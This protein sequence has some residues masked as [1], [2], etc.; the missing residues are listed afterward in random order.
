MKNKKEM[1]NKALFK[2][3]F[4]LISLLS[5]IGII[6]YVLIIF[7]FDFEALSFDSNYNLI[8]PIFFIAMLA[9]G[10]Y[11]IDYFKTTFL[12]NLSFGLTRKENMD[13]YFKTILLVLLMLLVF[14][15]VY[16][17]TIFVYLLCKG[18]FFIDC[19][20]LISKLIEIEMLFDVVS[21]YIFCNATIALISN[22]LSKILKGKEIIIIISY[23]L[24]I[25][26]LFIL[27]IIYN[28]LNGHI[29]INLL[30]LIFGIILFFINYK[31]TLKKNY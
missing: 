14:S 22:L 3:S 6:L 9:S 19:I 8:A 24:V 15:F 26:T 5:I 23:V 4:L 7:S 11:S 27:N 30:F 1:K 29:I 16:L 20:K 25:S 2:N 12:Y 21:Y 18:V 17:I 13:R 28:I 10:L 31:V